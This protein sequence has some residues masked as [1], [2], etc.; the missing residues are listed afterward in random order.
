LTIG[1]RWL[2]PGGEKVNDVDG[3]TALLAN[4]P[5]GGTV[6]LPLTITAPNGPGI[7]IMQLDAIQ[8]GVAWFGDR[9][10]QVLSLSI[11]VE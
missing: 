3:R 8:E 1:N 11:R 6:E 2:K 9:G 5:P 7:Y 10:S 4:L